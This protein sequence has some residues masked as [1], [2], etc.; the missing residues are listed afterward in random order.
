MIYHV[1]MLG[2][3]GLADGMESV[4]AAS[5]RSRHSCVAG[6]AF[7]K[8]PLVAL[9]LNTVKII[10]VLERGKFGVGGTVACLAIESAVTF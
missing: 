8:H 3:P 5:N 7:N 10:I 1:M 9:M 4:R 2:H 6:K